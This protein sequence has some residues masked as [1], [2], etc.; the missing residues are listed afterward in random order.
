MPVRSN[1]GSP[2]IIEQVDKGGNHLK[3]VMVGAC[4]VFGR[5]GLPA[6]YVL[7]CIVVFGFGMGNTAY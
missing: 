6:L 2:R 3:R 7:F 1:N 4:V 5:V